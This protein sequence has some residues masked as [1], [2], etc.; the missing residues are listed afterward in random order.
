MT[1]FDLGPRP[2]LEPVGNVPEIRLEQDNYTALMIQEPLP[3][4][5]RMIM[6]GGDWIVECTKPRPWWFRRF[7]W[8]ALLGIR[9]EKVGK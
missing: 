4:R 1:S 9:F 3:T 5:S 2:E 6:L 8:W 7:F